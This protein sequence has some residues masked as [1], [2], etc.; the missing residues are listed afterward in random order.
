MRDRAYIRILNG[1]PAI[2]VGFPDA[3]HVIVSINGNTCCLSRAYW[4]SLR[5]CRS[6]R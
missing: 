6:L 3:E 2:F 4:R 1:Q 5:I